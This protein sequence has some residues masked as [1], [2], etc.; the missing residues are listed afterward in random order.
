M[1]RQPAAVLTLRVA[2]AL[3]ALAAFDRLAPHI[4][5]SPDTAVQ[6]AGLGYAVT[7]TV[8]MLVPAVY[9]IGSFFQFFFWTV[10]SA[11]AP[12]W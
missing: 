6:I 12:A 5:N 9:V 1:V 11:S 7:Q 3:A 8:L 10:H 4:G 2:G